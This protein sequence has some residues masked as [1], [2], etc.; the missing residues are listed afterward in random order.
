MSASASLYDI[1]CREHSETLRLGRFAEIDSIAFAATIDRPKL[2][3]KIEE[4]SSFNPFRVRLWSMI[5][6]FVNRAHRAC[7]IRVND[8]AARGD[9]TA[10]RSGWRCCC[11]MESAQNLDGFNGVEVLKQALRAQPDEGHLPVK[12]YFLADDPE[13]YLLLEMERLQQFGHLY[14]PI[15]TAL[16]DY[17]ASKI[18]SR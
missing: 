8:D 9:D 18:V 12:V 6:Y 1:C 10:G 16:T 2:R 3:Q 17:L 7:P 13:Q 15:N 5:D 4:I 14:E 11:I